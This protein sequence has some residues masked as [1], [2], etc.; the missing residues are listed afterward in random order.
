MKLI[1]NKKEKVK[2]IIREIEELEGDLRSKISIYRQA[3]KEIKDLIKLMALEVKP[4]SS[5]CLECKF[6]NKSKN[7]KECMECD[8]RIVYVEK[9]QNS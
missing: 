6:K 9:V 8:L 1:E 5:P 2:K 3:E 4:I 7:R